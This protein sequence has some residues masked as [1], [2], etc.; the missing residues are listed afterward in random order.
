MSQTWWFGKIPTLWHS[1][2]C[3]ATYTER[4]KAFS[5]LSLFVKTDFCVFSANKQVLSN[6]CWIDS[7]TEEKTVQ[8]SLLR[9][10]RTNI[11]ACK[12]QNHYRGWLICVGEKQHCKFIAQIPSKHNVNYLINNGN[13]MKLKLV[14]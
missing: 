13:T 14:M 1:R 7:V 9:Q 8:N 4:N 2:L 6:K 10:A 5:K 11:T 3:Y 12:V